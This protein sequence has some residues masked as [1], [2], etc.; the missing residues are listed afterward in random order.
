MIV[1]AFYN[2]R[3][4]IGTLMMILVFLRISLS[5]ASAVMTVPDQ[6]FNEA[7]L[8]KNVPSV[9][10]YFFMFV[11]TAFFLL[12]PFVIQLLFRQNGR[13]SHT[14][15]HS[16]PYGLQASRRSAG[17]L[18]EYSSS[19]FALQGRGN[20]LY[21]YYRWVKVVVFFSFPTNFWTCPGILIGTLVYARLEYMH[22]S[23]HVVFPWVAEAII[24]PSILDW[25][26]KSFFVSILSCVVSIC[27]LLWSQSCIYFIAIYRVA[28]W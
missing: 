25:Q 16:W 9:V 20:H 7:C 22:D 24:T 14:E 15:Y 26:L 28:A 12:F 6:E 19:V 8:N 17:R 13:I 21:S 27:R 2:R 10:M 4:W 3:R 1:Y 11:I 23:A 5:S 18:G